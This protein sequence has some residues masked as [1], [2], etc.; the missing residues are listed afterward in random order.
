VAPPL[1]NGATAAAR[2]LRWQSCA[3]DPWPESARNKLTNL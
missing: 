2:G 3:A 1:A